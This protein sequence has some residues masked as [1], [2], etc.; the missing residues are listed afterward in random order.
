M[1][2]WKPEFVPQRTKYLPVTVCVL[3]NKLRFSDS[4]IPRGPKYLSRSLY[5]DFRLAHRL[6]EL[7]KSESWELADLARGMV[8]SG[9]TIRNLHG[10]NPRRM[11]RFITATAA[12]NYFSH[13]AG[14]RY[15]ARGKIR[16]Q[17]VTVHLPAGFL[18][19]VDLYARSH[20]RSRNDALSMLLQDGLR[21]YLIGYKYFLEA[22]LEPREAAEP[23]LQ[24]GG[25]KRNSVGSGS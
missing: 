18:K 24:E 13:G 23:Q 4:P 11:E 2:H 8:I 22:A 20:G 6:R 21:L 3:G 16:G 12:L 7:A 17:W 10:A 15:G 19:H 9:L 5:L 1:Q 14:R 25:E